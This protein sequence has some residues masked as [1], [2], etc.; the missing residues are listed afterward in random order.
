MIEELFPEV[1]RRTRKLLATS[2]ANFGLD[3]ATVERL[4]PRLASREGQARLFPEIENTIGAGFFSVR[5]SILEVGSGTGSFVVPALE[6][7]HDAYGIEIDP[8]RLD[9]AYARIDEYRLPSEW[10]SR[11]PR[12]DA[13]HTPYDSNSFDIVMGHQFIEHVPDAPGAISE[14]LRVAKPG[15]FVVLYA[16]DYRAPFEAHYE[17]PWPPFAAR[18]MLECWLDAFGRPYGGLDHIFP[19]TLLQLAGVFQALNCDLVRAS[20]DFEIEAHVG[21]H[22]T[23]N[24]EDAIRATAQQ[25]RAGQAAG[26]LPRNFMIPTSLA[27]AARKR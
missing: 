27:I 3:D 5:R 11:M 20:N 24:G 15:G 17:I 2:A 19:V 8:E 22:F 21:R 13:M 1:E 25:M 23:M 26:T 4:L 18:W 12:G 10:K 16:P 7:G 14:M 6:R 9:V